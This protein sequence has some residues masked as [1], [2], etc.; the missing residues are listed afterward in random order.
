MILLTDGTGTI[1]KSYEYDAFGREWD[2]MATDNNPFRYCGEYYDKR[3]E[4]V[5]LRAR[6]YDS[7]Y[8]RF[9]QEDPI[10]DGTNWY[11]YCDGNPVN[12]RDPSGCQRTA[13]EYL[14][15]TSM[16]RTLSE[17]KGINETSMRR[18]PSEHRGVNETPLEATYIYDQSKDERTKDVPYGS[19]WFVNTM[20]KNGC[21]IV[22]IYNAMIALGEPRTF[23]SI[24]KWGEKN[25][26]WFFGNFGTKVNAAHDYLS[27]SGY[28]V[29]TINKP[30][31]DELQTFVNEH[32]VVIFSY[33]TGTP[34]LSTIHTVKIMKDNTSDGYIIY[35]R[36]SN[37][38]GYD[39]TA[40]ECVNQG[41]I[42]VSYGMNR[43]G[44]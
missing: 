25:A 20:D 39:F 4:T 21:E 31:K 34:Y 1:V 18:T 8:G 36:W 14:G 10:R 12:Y 22:A 38:T 15:L 32:D 42:I 33:W 29:E 30:N 28:D 6:Y 16:R 5:Y 35:N 40:K 17:H 23:N 13:V 2:V 27:N 19:G 24:K 9:T 43:K 37:G 26:L 11:I 41:R 3:T 44:G 7:A